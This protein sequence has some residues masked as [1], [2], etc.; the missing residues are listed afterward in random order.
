MSTDRKNR[1]TFGNGAWIEWGYTP[2]GGGY[3][4]DS[5]GWQH[6]FSNADGTAAEQAEEAWLAY[7]A[8]VIFDIA[9]T[10]RDVRGHTTSM[11]GVRVALITDNNWWWVATMENISRAAKTYGHP[12]ALFDNYGSH[13]D[14]CQGYLRELRS[15]RNTEGF[16]PVQR[17]A[18]N[19]LLLHAEADV[20]VGRASAAAR[21]AT[22]SGED[23][24]YFSIYEHR[25]SRITVADQL[26]WS[27][28]PIFGDPQCSVD[29]VCASG[30]QLTWVIEGARYDVFSAWDLPKTPH[31]VYR[32][33][34]TNSGGG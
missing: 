13:T 2:T 12:T 34:R 25:E 15:A 30:E 19:A 14:A 24:I 22:A 5:L 11:G 1:H 16:T 18:W 29:E 9:H 4:I 23:G 3:L 26:D 21:E 31:G 7:V 32:S 8:A 17:H 10:Y 33:D 20:S 27:G 6:T 28:R